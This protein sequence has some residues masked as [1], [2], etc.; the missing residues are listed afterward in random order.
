MHTSDQWSHGGL[1]ALSGGLSGPVSSWRLLFGRRK[2][3]EVHAPLLELRSRLG[4]KLDDK[5]VQLSSLVTVW[6]A[7][8]GLRA[9]RGSPRRPDTDT[10]M[11][12][13][14]D[15]HGGEMLGLRYEGLGDVLKGQHLAETILHGVEHAKRE[16]TVGDSMSWCAGRKR[17]P[18]PWP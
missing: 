6:Y 4:G 11:V 9:H 5:L 12:G 7:R 1:V 16:P 14:R 8:A 17:S 18:R 3:V 15:R 10:M 13:K 2:R